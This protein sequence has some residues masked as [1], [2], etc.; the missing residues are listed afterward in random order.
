MLQVADNSFN[1][2]I[3]TINSTLTSLQNQINA[4]PA[5]LIVETS[6]TQF[7]PSILT[8]QGNGIGS[9]GWFPNT[10]ELVVS[11]Q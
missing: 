11:F 1:A 3:A 4:I 7:Q 6:G 9:V 10:T 2:Q 5:P 8:L